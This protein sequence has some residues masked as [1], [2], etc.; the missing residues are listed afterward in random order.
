[1]L[2]T[3]GWKRFRYNLLAPIHDLGAARFPEERKRSIALAALAAG[4][5][6]LVVGAGTGDD[7]PY[8]P[9]GIEALAVDLAPA[10]LARALEKARR[11][12]ARIELKVMDA[13]LLDLPD[14]A[15]DAVFLHQVLQVVPAPARALA[16]AARVTRSG[17]RIAVFDKFLPR[18]E[19]ATPLDRLIDPFF[20][21]ATR[22]FEEILDGAG[23]PLVIEHQ[24]TAGP[25][26][27]RIVLARKVESRA[28][29]SFTTGC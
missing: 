7:L 12:P 18:G 6:V 19:R 29:G 25:R 16:E 28:A 2:N 13:H 11:S 20:T 22:S 14:A 24:E 8:L 21:T 26:G 27:F 4:E 5:R 10:M 3:N 1:M 23:A 9:A 17:G 15:F